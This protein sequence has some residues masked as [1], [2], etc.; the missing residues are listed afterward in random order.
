MAEYYYTGGI[1]LNVNPRGRVGDVVHMLQNTVGN[2]NIDYHSVVQE[3][4]NLN[5]G[6]SRIHGLEP[7][8]SLPDLNALVGIDEEF[9]PGAFDE[10]RQS[11]WKYI[12]MGLGLISTAA[13]GFMRG[14]AEY[15]SDTGTR[16]NKAET[17][18]RGESRV[19]MRNE[20]VAVRA[21]QAQTERPETSAVAQI[22]AT[23]NVTPRV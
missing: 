9:H 22:S 7:R 10:R 5:T 3:F 17:V 8:Y 1:D 4:G 11:P 19:A 14:S 15:Q 16:A 2:N 18:T 21:V 6:T 23:S 20:S 12:T 13:V